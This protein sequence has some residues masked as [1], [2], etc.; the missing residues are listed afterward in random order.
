MDNLDEKFQALQLQCAE[1]TLKCGSSAAKLKKL[2]QQLLE[3][4]AI[5]AENKRL[6][7]DNNKVKELQQQKQI[8]EG[9]LAHAKFI[10][11][12]IATSP[13][14]TAAQKLAMITKRILR[15]FKKW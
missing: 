7:S 14:F 4:E 12:S 13:T 10:L 9:E 11:E 15:I 6:S 1:L 2:E 5:K 8:L 3:M